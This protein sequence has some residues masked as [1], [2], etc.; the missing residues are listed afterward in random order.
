M[1]NA[2]GHCLTWDCSRSP[3]AETVT[4]Q[5]PS[6]CTSACEPHFSSLI[7]GTLVHPLKG[8]AF[9]WGHSLKTSAPDLIKAWIKHIWHFLDKTTWNLV[10]FCGRIT[11]GRSRRYHIL[12][13][14]DTDMYYYST[15]DTETQFR[16]N[17]YRTSTNWL[18][19]H[20]L[21]VFV[22]G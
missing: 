4:P 22:S 11:D 1:E 2:Q 13:V 21:E 17:W 7:S 14:S 12:I 8:P 16:G 10:S 9:T 18:G 15:S 5:L 6:R 3:T 19:N 20:S